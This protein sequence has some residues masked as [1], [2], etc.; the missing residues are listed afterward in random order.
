MKIE[1]F[2]GLWI[3]FMQLYG[4]IIFKEI[5]MESQNNYLAL[6][7]NSE[8]IPDLPLPYPMFEIFVYSPR[9]EGVHLRS[10]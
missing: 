5:L 9:F 2:D 7:L 8:Q 1:L 10:C 3:L 6:K 4:P